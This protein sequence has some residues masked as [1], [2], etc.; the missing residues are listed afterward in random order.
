MG[1]D[2]REIAGRTEH[3]ARNRFHRL[4]SRGAQ[5]MTS[6]LDG[7]MAYVPPVDS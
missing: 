2:R 1:R 4:S 7:A 3:A 5:G 6:G